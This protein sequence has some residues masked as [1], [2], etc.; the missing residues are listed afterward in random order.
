MAARRDGKR[1]PAARGRLRYQSQAQPFA[2]QLSVSLLL[3]VAM[4]AV[5]VPSPPA[6]V[7]TQPHKHV[8][9]AALYHRAKCQCVVQILYAAHAPYEARAAQAAHAAHAAHAAQALLQAMTIECAGQSCHLRVFAPAAA[10]E[11]G[12][13]RYTSAY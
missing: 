2:P 12:A 1:S 4:V 3:A 13:G 7:P 9:Y 8:E 11:R 6:A 10:I 5:T